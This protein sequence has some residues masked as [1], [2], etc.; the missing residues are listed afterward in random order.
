MASVGGR[1][2][3]SDP[4][5]ACEG[6]DPRIPF[7]PDTAKENCRLA[8]AAGYLDE[9]LKSLV[10]LAVW[11]LGDDAPARVHSL[12]L[13][14]EEIK[15]LEEL[16]DGSLYEFLIESAT[17]HEHRIQI[18]DAHLRDLKHEYD[19]PA[20]RTDHF[21]RS[22][23][24][25]DLVGASMLARQDLVQV[26]VERQLTV[27]EGVVDVRFEGYMLV[28]SGRQGQPTA[29]PDVPQLGYSLKVAS[30]P[31]GGRR[32]VAQFGQSLIPVIEDFT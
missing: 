15:N 9:H 20:M 25:P 11:H 18:A 5:V 22:E 21:K 3:W 1:G 23:Q 17:V 12:R 26:L 28:I 6:R 27:P 14:V 24:L 8:Q 16:L 31:D 13:C 19:V 32:A 7:P 29:K 2:R 10:S 30:K 4:Q